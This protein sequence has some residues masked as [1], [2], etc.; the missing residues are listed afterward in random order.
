MMKRN[1]HILYLSIFITIQSSASYAQPDTL[2]YYFDKSINRCEKSDA[3]ISGI[4]VKEQGKFKFS[5]Y[6]TET[7]IPLFKGWFLDSTLTVKE[8]LFTYYDSS[9]IKESEGVFHKNVE[10]GYWIKWIGGYLADSI[11][12]KK[13]QKTEQISF[14]YHY[15]GKLSG[16]TLFN[17]RNNIMDIT[18]WYSDGSLKLKSKT[19]NGAG[20]ETKYYPNGKVESVVHYRNGTVEQEEFYNDDGTE[21]TKEEIEKK[22]KSFKDI[23][24]FLA[25]NGPSFPNGPIGFINYFTKNFNPPKISRSGQFRQAVTVSFYLNKAGFAYDIQVSESSNKNLEIEI[26]SLLRRMPAW[27]MNGYESFGP[28]TFTLNLA[29]LF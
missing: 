9:G 21:M 18:E 28:I 11:L 13:G 20:D 12:Y 22:K 19:G 6:Y 2:I 14:R 23:L 7:G 15:S 5:A 24:S 17:M 29:N 8:G 4:G 1:W 25:V 26:K 16:R 27:D 10:T 3:I